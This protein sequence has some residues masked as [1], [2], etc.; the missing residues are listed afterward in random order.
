[1]FT[2]ADDTRD[3]DVAQVRVVNRKGKKYVAFGTLVLAPRRELIAAC[4]QVEALD[5]GAAYRRPQLLTQC[6]H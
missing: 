6:R 5:L 3:Y 2:H 4:V 1:M